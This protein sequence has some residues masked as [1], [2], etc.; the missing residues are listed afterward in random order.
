[1]QKP[2]YISEIDFKLLKEKYPNNLE[3]KLE[4]INNNYPIQYLLGNVNFYGYT[5][6]SDERALIPRFE[7]EGLVDE[8]IKLSK[9]M[10]N[11]YKIL[12]IG[13]GSGCISIVLSKELNTHVDA[14]EI[15]KPAINLAI[16]NTLLNEADVTYYNKDIKN[17]NIEN[18]Y[19]ILIS[20]PPYVKKTETVDERTKYEPQNAIF[21]DD[22]G[23][24]FYKIILNKSVDFLEKKNLIAFEIGMTQGQD[25]KEYASKI[26]PKSKIIIKKDLSDRDRYLF[27]IND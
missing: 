14:V 21:A 24:E 7:T 5:I 27:I 17:C 9:V 19:N 8:T 23:L 18:K 13:S 11:D 10:F 22:D 4:Q 15:S 20:N 2:D 16:D 12:E 26:Y 6:N 3:E 1:M 25:I